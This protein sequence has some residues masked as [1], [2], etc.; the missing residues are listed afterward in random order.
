M[1]IFNLFRY[2]FVHFSEVDEE[3][4]DNR[5]VLIFKGIDGFTDADLVCNKVALFKVNFLLNDVR[6]GLQ[7]VVFYLQGYYQDVGLDVVHQLFVVLH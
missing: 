6:E 3:V 2:L 4:E 7:D 5:Q 1:A